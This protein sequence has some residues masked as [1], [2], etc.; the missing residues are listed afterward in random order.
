MAHQENATAAYVDDLVIHLGSWEEHLVRLLKIL[1]DLRKA[2]LATNPRKCHLGLAE[3]LYPGF[4]I[5]CGVIQPQ[6]QKVEAVQKAPRPS[7]NTQVRGF[8]WSYLLSL[9]YP[10]P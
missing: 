5:R 9:F 10:V 7:T 1:L 8:L 6:P 4:R 3:A 2:G